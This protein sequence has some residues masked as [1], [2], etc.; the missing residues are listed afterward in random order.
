MEADIAIIKVE[1]ME[2]SSENVKEQLIY[3]Q[4]D[5]QKYT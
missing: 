5:I 4:A 3:L 2:M 1:S